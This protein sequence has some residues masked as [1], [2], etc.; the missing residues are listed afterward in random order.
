MQV[1]IHCLGEGEETEETTRG[2]CGERYKK[3]GGRLYWWVFYDTI[4]FVLVVGLIATS[5]FLRSTPLDD[6]EESQKI[7]RQD[8]FWA[9]TIYGLFS[10]PF[11]IFKLPLMFTLLTH[12]KVCPFTIDSPLIITTFSQRDIAQPVF[13]SQF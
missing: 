2:I 4:V 11:V 9:K 13:V 5:A 12:A 3:R 1:T 6:F 8:L 7:L 10:F